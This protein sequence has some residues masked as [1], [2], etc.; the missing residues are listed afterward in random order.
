MFTLGNKIQYTNRMSE[1]MDSNSQ[2]LSVL[3]GKIDTNKMYRRS[4]GLSLIFG[5]SMSIY[6]IFKEI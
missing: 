2:M 5:M 1:M 3:A 6:V 4:H